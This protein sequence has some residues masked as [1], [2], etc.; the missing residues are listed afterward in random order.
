MIHLKKGNGT[1][2]TL[3]LTM[4]S[5]SSVVFSGTLV[6][7][8]L[9]VPNTFSSGTTISSSAMNE[10]FTAVKT[11]VDDNDTRIITNASAI[12]DNASDISNNASDI[13]GN[14]SEISTNAGNININS[15]N[16]TTN[17]TSINTNTANIT[18]NAGNIATLQT[19][20]ANLQSSSSCQGQDASDEMVQV[21]PFCIDKYE[22]SVWDTADGTGTQFG[23]T[24]GG[25][26]YLCSDNG[27]DCTAGT[28]N[29]IFARSQAGVE[30]SRSI[31]WFQ[32]QQACANVGKRLL[33]N[34]E[35][36]M[37]AAGTNE[38]NCLSGTG[39]VALTDANATCVSTYGAI[40][41][42]GNVWEWVVDWM[43]GAAVSGTNNTNTL[44]YG[45]DS[46]VNTGA[47][48]A[49]GGGANFPA[50]IL[51]GGGVDGTNIGIFAFAAFHA[52]SNSTNEFGFR[53][54]R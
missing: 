35:W 45:S 29:P 40:N 5:A 50:A 27:N 38:A 21:G 4:I 13:S 17:T 2:K 54:A 31:T 19:D 10:N 33:T 32:A 28:A 48:T 8:Q 12:S 41:M 6:A 53:C 9:D 34:A 24:A 25:D 43:Q 47:P 7:S 18:T 49:Q 30:P 11:A 15:A 16:I 42:A 46:M 22:A 1:M 44:L 20:V 23:D 39:P 37:A 52:P 14:V 26:N 3:A 51:R 36:Q